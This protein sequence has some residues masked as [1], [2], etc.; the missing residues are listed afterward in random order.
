MAAS[1]VSPF[2]GGASWEFCWRDKN[3]K[4]E[5]SMRRRTCWPH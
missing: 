1:F 2:F 5:N 4:S 3:W